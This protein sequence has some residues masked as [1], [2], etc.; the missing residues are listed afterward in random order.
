MEIE[1]KLALPSADPA[2]LEQRLAR[3][4]LLARRKASRQALHNIYFDTPDD[5]LRQRRMALRL[6]RVGDVA[7]PQWLQTLKVGG[8]D[9]SALSR[10]GEWE[11]AV[12]HAALSLPLLQTTPWPELDP[13]GA[14][15]RS[16]EPRFTTDFQRTRWTVRQR[17]GSVIEV[18]LDVGHIILGAHTAPLCELELELLAGDAE[19]LLEVA[20]RIAR[21][22]AVLPLGS[23]KAESGYAL[24]RH[25]LHQPRRAQPPVLA[26][27]TPQTVAAA[28][29]LREIWGQFT[30]NLVTLQFDEDPELVHQTRVAWRRFRSALKLFKRTEWVQAAPA[31]Q[32]LRPLLQAL[33]DL[34]DL[35][36]AHLE[37]L[38]MLA[39]AYAAGDRVRQTHWCAMQE[40]LVHAT[41]RQRH[42]ARTALLDPAVGADLLATTTWLE[43]GLATHHADTTDEGRKPNLRRWAQ[44]QVTRLREQLK[45]SLKDVEHPLSAHRARILS[46]R[47]RYAIESLRPLLPKRRCQR[48]YQQAVR[49]QGELGAQRDLRQAL[50][51]T[52]RLQAHAGLQEFLRGVQARMDQAR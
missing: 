18:A 47:L 22:I 3:L 34:R 45:A 44:G 20:S 10:R 48:W 35:D 42:R 12:A 40:A 17:N 36:V 43:R 8:S 16:L 31:W 29:V 38:P 49:V 13:N 24:A 51:I 9:D 30:H 19:A 33:G 37:T 26:P 28:Q 27:R 7:Q 25:E 4:P 32:G 2:T 1:L 14:I 15:F 6:R 39:N 21:Q 52:A 11:H 5:A 41:D 46:K 23:S 50:E